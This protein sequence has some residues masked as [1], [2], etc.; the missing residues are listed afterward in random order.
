MYL[1]GIVVLGV[2]GYWI[3]KK[4]QAA[5]VKQE[6]QQKNRERWR[7]YAATRRSRRKAGKV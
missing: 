1:I 7:K 4:V 6:Q 5:K 3:G 2:V